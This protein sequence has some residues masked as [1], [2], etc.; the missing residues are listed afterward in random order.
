MVD[1]FEG[2]QKL[3]SGGGIDPLDGLLGR[4]DRVEEILALTD[5]ELVPRL[6]LKILFVGHRIHRT[7]GIQLPFEL[8]ELLSKPLIVFAEI[9]GA[10]QLGRIL[11]C[12]L[13]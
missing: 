10:Q 5:E 2:F 3:L 7:D 9:P 11:Q 6:Q 8:G 12:Y 13:V 1:P 4:P